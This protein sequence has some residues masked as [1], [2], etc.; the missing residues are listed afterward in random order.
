MLQTK[1]VAKLYL[2]VT[3]RGDR[4]LGNGFL[5][6]GRA[7]RSPV[8]AQETEDERVLRWR[9][10]KGGWVGCEPIGLSTFSCA[11]V[12]VIPAG[13]MW[14]PVGDAANV[15]HGHYYRDSRLTIDQM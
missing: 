9:R 7:T 15:R 1:A 2:T 13:A 11:T 14:W 6:S 8:E 10:E 4:S 12:C 3:K 5:F